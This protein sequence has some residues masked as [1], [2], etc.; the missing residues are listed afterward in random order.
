M[1]KRELSVV[2]SEPTTLEEVPE[3]ELMAEDE[4]E[5]MTVRPE[6][7]VKRKRGA[8]PDGYKAKGCVVYL[9]AETQKRVDARD[10]DLLL[11]LSSEDAVHLLKLGAIEPIWE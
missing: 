5:Q 7:P 10:G 3:A 1:G 9:S 6:K 4:E 8:Q 11:D 2:G